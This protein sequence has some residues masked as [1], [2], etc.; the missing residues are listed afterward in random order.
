MRAADRP[1]IRRLWRLGS[2]ISI[3]PGRSALPGDGE[4][5]SVYG[6]VV[7]GAEADQVVGVGGAAVFPVDDVVDDKVVGDGAAGDGAAAGGV[8]VPATARR[9]AIGVRLR[10]GRRRWSRPAPTHGR[11]RRHRSPTNTPAAHR[12]AAIG[13]VWSTDNNPSSNN[14]VTAGRSERRAA[15]RA[16]SRPRPVD[17]PSCHDRNC[18]SDRTPVPPNRPSA[19]TSAAISVT[20]P[21]KALICPAISPSSEVTSSQRRSAAVSINDTSNGASASA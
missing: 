11:P 14:P 8:C 20:R 7:C 1:V 17:R 6:A 12:R 13:A 2:R 21:N 16:N 19:S 15:I 5:A 3:P 10:S 18:A 9:D 4:L